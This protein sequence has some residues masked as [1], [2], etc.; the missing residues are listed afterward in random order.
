MRQL[1]MAEILLV[2]GGNHERRTEKHCRKRDK[3]ATAV[4]D[5]E[6]DTRQAA[7]AVRKLEKFDD[8]HDGLECTSQGGS[9]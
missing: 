9:T 7:K 2:S 4:A 8:K 3:L 1:T 5:A 6:D